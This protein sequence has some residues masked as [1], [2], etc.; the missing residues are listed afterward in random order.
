MTAP[1]QGGADLAVAPEAWLKEN[2]TLSNRQ[3]FR[4]ALARFADDDARVV[5]LEA[6]L[7]GGGDAFEAR[8]PDRF[9]N[10]GIC[11]ATM[12]DA[13]CGMAAAG[14]VVFAHTFAAEGEHDQA[15]D[16]DGDHSCR[17]DREQRGHRASAGVS[18]R[19]TSSEPP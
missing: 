1:A 19:M 5:L 18:S 15:H 7:A 17:L 13:A 10:L 2:P 16:D 11:E 12:I 8:H 14:Q 3:V 6:D 9:L 4:H